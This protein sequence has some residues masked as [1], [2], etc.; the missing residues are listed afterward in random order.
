MPNHLDNQRE[1]DDDS[2]FADD[3]SDPEIE[4]VRHDDDGGR[5]VDRCVLGDAC[6][7][8]DPNHGPDECWSAEDVEA[9][10]AELGRGGA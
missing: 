3:Y 8:A 10:E 5:L 2:S 1:L 9:Y 7:A 6:V 4:S